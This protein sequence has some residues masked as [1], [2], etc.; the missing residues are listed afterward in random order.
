MVCWEEGGRPA[1]HKLAVACFDAEKTLNILD[2]ANRPSV[3]ID[4]YEPT[5][6]SEAYFV[7]SYMASYLIC[8]PLLA[9]CSI[10]AHHRGSPF[11]E[12]YI[13]PQLLLQWLR[14]ES[15]KIDGIRY[16]S[17]RVNQTSKAP[18]LG[19]NY[20]FPVKTD[21][22][23]TG[24]CSQ[25][26]RRF[27]FTLPIPWSLLEVSD[28]QSTATLRKNEPYQL[29]SEQMINYDDTIFGKLEARLNL[30]DKQYL[31]YVPQS[32]TGK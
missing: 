21:A 2:F 18:R 17:M 20:V 9:A 14:D 3:V 7:H 23:V 32:T 10:S 15:L 12:E 26:T 28:F 22:A 25:L 16:F 5:D 6:G 11:V 27:T 1:F 8:W 24:H 29:D 4:L 30:R 19:V 31:T 13:V